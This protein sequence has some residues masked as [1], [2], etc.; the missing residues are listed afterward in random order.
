MARR[1]VEGDG[2]TRQW[3]RDGVGV[4]EEASRGAF[5]IYLESKAVS[6]NQ[7][8]F[9]AKQQTG[10]LLPRVGEGGGGIRR[11][12]KKRVVKERGKE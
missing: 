4:W 5:Q 6:S 9:N 8:L 11:R 7:H 10:A 1:G 2:P 3:R 12:T